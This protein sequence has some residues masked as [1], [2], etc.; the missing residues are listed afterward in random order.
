MLSEQEED[1]VAGLLPDMEKEARAA[2]F[3]R[4]EPLY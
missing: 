1:I 3:E 4:L 2:L